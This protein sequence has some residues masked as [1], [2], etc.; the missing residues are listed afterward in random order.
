MPISD[1]DRQRNREL[2]QQMSPREKL[3]HIWLYY[4][5]AFLLAAILVVILVSSVISLAT[6]KEPVLH[7]AYT[8]VTL[9]A[10]SEQ[11]L[12]TDYL[13]ARELDPQKT[14]VY[15]HRDLYLSDYPSAENYE[16]A[17]T[18]YM[19]VIALVESQE[20]DILLMNREAYDF[21]STSGFLLEL[22]ELFPA[23]DPRIAPYAASNLI[24]LEDNGEDYSLGLAEEYICVT[25][26]VTN[27]LELTRMPWIQDT[28]LSGEV[29]LGI[30][31]TSPRLDACADYIAYLTEH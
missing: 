9:D 5:P 2:F 17:Y 1:K 28:G 21:C 18:S 13:T 14:E 4:K 6:R 15:L 31:V 11:A 24:V 3:S 30:V 16:Y 25:D 10:A 27:A 20:L 8:N 19:K 7:A 23:D 29:Y 22:S 12:W 26:T